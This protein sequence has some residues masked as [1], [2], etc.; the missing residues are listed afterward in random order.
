M[1]QSRYKCRHLC[2]CSCW[3]THV[4]HFADRHPQPGRRR[5][6]AYALISRYWIRYFCCSD[7]HRHLLRWQ[8]AIGPRYSRRGRPCN[9]HY[10]HARRRYPHVALRLWR[11]H[12]I[13]PEQ[14][15]RRLGNRP[16]SPFHNDLHY[17]T[18]RC[19][20]GS[21][22]NR[23]CQRRPHH[24]GAIFFAVLLLYCDRQYR[25]T[26]IRRRSHLHLTAA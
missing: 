22:S 13:L 9:L 16:A 24:K 10:P 18:R 23:Y 20:C 6:A 15:T 21:A 26:P 14:L 19:R 3:T 8:H 12:Y 17:R 25:R 4:F 5:S 2:L 11:R 7:R 1:I